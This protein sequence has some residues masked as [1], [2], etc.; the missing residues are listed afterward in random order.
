[1]T[2]NE[3][4]FEGSRGSSGSNVDTGHLERGGCLII[5]LMELRLETTLCE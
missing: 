3:V 1:M 2:G 4:Y 5:E